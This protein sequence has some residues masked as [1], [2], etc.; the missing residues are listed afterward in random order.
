MPD[1]NNH[2]AGS[3]PGTPHP[4]LRRLDL[5]VGTWEIS[6]SLVHGRLRFEWMEGGFYLIHHVELAHHGKRITG[7][8]YIGFDEDTQTLRSHFM[9]SNGANFTY[10]WDLTGRTLLTWFG[11]KDS[12]NFFRGQLTED[13]SRY[14][15]SWQ[16]PDGQGGTGGYDATAV[17]VTA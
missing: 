17:R 8:E 11:D 15:G 12:A 7:V 9:D 10:T 14:D 1:S 16:W 13:G 6:G 4:A 2:R 3:L 5:L